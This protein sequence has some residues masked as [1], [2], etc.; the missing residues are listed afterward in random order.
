MARLSK[1]EERRRVYYLVSRIYRLLRQ[2]EWHVRLL[3]IPEDLTEEQR[4]DLGQ[5]RGLCRGR[6]GQQVIH[7]FLEDGTGEI[8][9][10]YRLDLLPTLVHE[11]LHL[12]YEDLPEKA[13]Y[14]LERLVM[15]HLSSR[16]A[17]N[18]IHLL[19]ENL[20]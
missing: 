20:L 19:V 9:L 12:L 6:T 1:A 8:C 7:G 17:V 15:R 4:H 2:N 14:R 18:L 16:Q 11:C 5:K 10:D 3:R 13:V